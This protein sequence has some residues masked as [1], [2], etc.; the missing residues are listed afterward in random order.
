[1]S[2]YETVRGA[3]SESMAYAKLIDLLKQAADQAYILGHIIKSQSNDSLH[4]TK[5]Q[6][7]LAIGQ[8]IERTTIT[9]TDLAVKGKLQ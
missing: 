5:G 7:F 1:M 9:I 8:L 3:P 6:G 4:Q 2:K